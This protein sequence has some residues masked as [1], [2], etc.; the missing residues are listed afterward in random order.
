MNG[1]FAWDIWVPFDKE[2]LKTFPYY[3]IVVVIQIIGESF[4][5]YFA[6][7]P[8]DMFFVINMG[9]VCGQF[10]LLKAEFNNIG[11]NEDYN[12]V[13]KCV[14]Q[15][16]LILLSGS[17]RFIFIVA[18]ASLQIL[19]YCFCG[20]IIKDQSFSVSLAIYNSDWENC[21]RATIR[22]IQNIM[23]RAHRE[24]IITMGGFQGLSLEGFV[25]IVRT[26]FS[27][28]TVMRE[29]IQYD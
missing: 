28:T 26:I 13:I 11:K 4:A 22:S 29:T 18:A 20:Q 16:N 21:D 24:E 9:L 27:F 5:A 15:H 23:C 17:F 3:E 2:S 14:K 25:N 1:N 19:F 6:M 12:V 8:F 10:H 7:V